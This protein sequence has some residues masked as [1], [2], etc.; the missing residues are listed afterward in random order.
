M[1][2]SNRQVPDRTGRPIVLITGAG[3][4]IGTRLV[5]Q[6]KD[7]YTLVG[8][9]LKLPDV[10]SLDVD[11]VQVDL[12]DTASVGQALTQVR[13]KH[14]N[15]IYSVIHLAAYYDFSGEPSP[16]YEQLT[17]EGTRRLLTALQEFDV[18]Q[19]VF[20]SSLLVMKPTDDHSE[21]TEES[22]TRAEWAYPE[23]K[24]EAEQIIEDL[25]DGISTVILRIAGVYDEQ[26]N[27]LPLSQQ[28]S[29]IYEKQMESYVFPGDSTNGNALVH[30]DDL[31]D[32]F[33]CVLQ[34]AGRLE[35]RE[36]FLVAEPDVMSY[37]QLQEELGEL[38]HGESWPAVRIPKAVAKAGAWVKNKLASEDDQQFIKPWMVNLADDHYAADIS[39]ANTILGWRPKHTLRETLP[40]IVD[41]LF[42]NPRQWYKRHDLNWPDDRDDLPLNRPEKR[43]EE[44]VSA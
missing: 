13:E 42:A 1:T 28:I 18:N 4:L 26:G 31:T 9:D 8:L 16:M 2:S 25:A 39:H 7:D 36:L 19:F 40:A 27:S 14:G 12:T 3:G 34:R 33:H 24:L 37:R 23:S 6:L 5:N 11:W 38:I 32:C 41:S 29:R 44:T 43:A 20:S 30:L 35:H 17:V 15:A 21:I 10:K 22:A